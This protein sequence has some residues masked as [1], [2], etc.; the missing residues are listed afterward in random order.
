MALLR[1]RRQR[2]TGVVAVLVGAVALGVVDAQLYLGR[3][4]GFWVSNMSAVWLMAPF[5][6]AAVAAGSRRSAVTVGWTVTLAAFA[7]FYGDTILRSANQFTKHD[8]LFLVGGILSGPMFGLLGRRWSTRHS[9]W[10]ATPLVAAFCLEP[11]AWRYHEGRLPNP[12]Y[13]WK[14]EVLVGVALGA[15][16]I[17]V[18]MRRFISSRSSPGPMVT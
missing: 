6:T 12:T 7:G 14:G 15:F 13:V 10:A 2:F 11:L 9:W 18:A 4:A 3:G 16:F 5:V 1:T 8:L 17:A